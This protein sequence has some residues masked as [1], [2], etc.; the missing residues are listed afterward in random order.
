MRQRTQLNN[1]LR[2]HLA[3]LG[4]VAA[5]GDSGVKE[6][7]AIVADDGEAR[8]PIDALASVIVLAAQLEAVQ[9]VIGA[10]E[11][12]IKSQHRS[13]EAS[14]RVETLPGIAVLGGDRD[15]GDGGG[16]DRVSV[17]TRFRGLDRSGAAPGP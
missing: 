4:I 6:L 10:I 15:R 13:N 3:E 14:Q 7:L 9:T 16:S 12:R 17:G 11:N 5:K 8:L 2:A 1:A